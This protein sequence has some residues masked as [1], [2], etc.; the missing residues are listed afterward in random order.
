MNLNDFLE[1]KNLEQLSCYLS[2]KCNNIQDLKDFAKAN[3]KQKKEIVAAFA[4]EINNNIEEFLK[5]LENK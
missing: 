4:D 1:N 3:E 2:H 5:N